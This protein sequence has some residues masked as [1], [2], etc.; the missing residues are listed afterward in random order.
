[1]TSGWP[2]SGSARRPFPHLTR[3]DLGEV[4]YAE[5]IG[6]MRQWVAECQS[7]AVGD[8]LFLLS[9]PPVVTYG[10]RTQPGDL[11]PATAGLDVVQVDRGGQATYHGPGQVVGYLIAHVRERGPADVV[12]WLEQGII[13]ALA[14]LGFLA[15][16]RQTLPGGPSLVGVWT[17]DNRKIASI[18]MRIRGGV[19]SHGFSVNVNPD[20]T[21]F[22]SFVSCGVTDPITSLRVLADERGG[23]APSETTVRDALATALGA[24]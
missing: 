7:G 9:H 19:S 3:I 4:P 6:A 12:R 21:V 18:G 10:P 23:P 20:M 22:D 11:P 17:P 13:T 24:T 16:R 14:T 2:G 1:M 8:R 15:V 5:A